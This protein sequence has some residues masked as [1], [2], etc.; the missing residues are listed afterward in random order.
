MIMAFAVINEKNNLENYQVLNT[1][2][3]WDRHSFSHADRV[4]TSLLNRQG[5]RVF[6]K[7]NAKASGPLDLVS[8]MV[9]A[10]H[11]INQPTICGVNFSNNIHQRPGSI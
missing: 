6:P 5:Q 7:M 10:L 2:F 8:E 9:K 3:A 1:G 11:K 4:N